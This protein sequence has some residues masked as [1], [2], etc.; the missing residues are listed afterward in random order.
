MT[1]E[2]LGESS[3]TIKVMFWINIFESPKADQNLLGE[4]VKS[5]MMRKTQGFVTGKRIQYARTNY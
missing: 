4:P 5:R 3:V 2:E 1:L